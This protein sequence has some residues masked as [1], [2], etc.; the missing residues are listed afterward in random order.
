MCS[1]RQARWGQGHEGAW[2]AAAAVVLEALPP[3]GSRPRSGPLRASPAALLLPCLGCR[4][5]APPARLQPRPLTDSIFRR[6]ACRPF[7]PCRSPGGVGGAARDGLRAAACHLP[8]RLCLPAFCLVQPTKLPLCPSL[9]AGILLSWP[10]WGTAACTSL[11]A[12]FPTAPRLPATTG[13]WPSVQVLQAAWLLAVAAG[14]R[15]RYSPRLAA[16]GSMGDAWKEEAPLPAHLGGSHATAV[17]LQPRGAGEW[18][19]GGPGKRGGKLWPCLRSAHTPLPRPPC[20]LCPQPR[21]RSM[22]GAAPARSSSPCGLQGMAQQPHVAPHAPASPALYLPS[23]CPASFLLRPS[24]DAGAPGDTC[25]A[26]REWGDAALWSF[27]TR[28]GWHRHR[29]LPLP[30]SHSA[31][32]TIKLGQGGWRSRTRT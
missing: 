28:R 8:A 13:A 18:C 14:R 32:C 9:A 16:D 2:A 25:I 15:Y 3:K 21:P 29:D 31:G 7:P 30:L 24:R 12:C 20:C 22:S 27:S 10:C 4:R 1:L 17:Q 5:R 23:C 6:W 19:G 11:A 26:G